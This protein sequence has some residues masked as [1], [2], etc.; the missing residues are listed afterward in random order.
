MIQIQNV[1]DI[2]SC[3]L[4]KCFIN[5]LCLCVCVGSSIKFNNK[6]K[7][8]TFIMELVEERLKLVEPFISFH[9]DISSTGDFCPEKTNRGQINCDFIFTTSVV[10]TDILG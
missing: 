2:L 5:Q 4:A 7:D 3:E 6:Y 10:L 8:C 1:L 9:L